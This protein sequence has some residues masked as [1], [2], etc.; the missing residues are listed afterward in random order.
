MR[1]P[2]KLRRRATNSCGTQTP[3]TPDAHEPESQAA[4]RLADD[5]LADDPLADDAS[6]R[7]QTEGE[8]G[9]QKGLLGQLLRRGGKPEEEHTDADHLLP[10]P[11]ALDEGAAGELT[12]T[13]DGIHELLSSGAATATEE[14]ASGMLDEPDQIYDAGSAERPE[15]EPIRFDNKPTTIFEPIFRYLLVLGLVLIVVAAILAI[16][17]LRHVGTTDEAAQ[18]QAAAGAGVAANSTAP[19]GRAAQ[20]AEEFARAYMAYPSSEDRAVEDY[21]ATLQP[22]LHPMADPALFEPEPGEDAAAREVS[23]ASARSVEQAPGEQRYRVVVDTRLT[24]AGGEEQQSTARSLAVTVKVPPEG[25]A[26][27]VLAPPRV[28]EAPASQ[29]AGQPGIYGYPGAQGLEENGMEPMVE[30]FFGAAYGPPDERALVEEQLADGTSVES[31]PPEEH[32]YEGIERAAVYYRDK[33]QQAEAQGYSSLYDVE[34]YVAVTD[35]ESGRRQLDSWAL[36]VGE[37]EKG[38]FEITNV[39]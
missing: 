36:T 15:A 31:F 18:S 3:P 27:Y 7:L 9:Q 17:A 6:A 28:S 11:E 39:S 13:D 5:P 12:D 23:Y 30:D 38:G 8:R 10:G 14:Q 34:I 1:L 4:G 24:P 32:T 20:L 26:A 35:D 25:S 2:R 37:H 21:I 16:N 22:Y 29:E 33:P 19:Q